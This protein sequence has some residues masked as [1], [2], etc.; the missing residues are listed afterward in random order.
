M[1]NAKG[2]IV[3][4]YESKVLFIIIYLNEE[5][6]NIK[7]NVPAPYPNIVVLIRFDKDVI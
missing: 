3:N 6:G 1:R 2:K 7:P 4:V 5:L